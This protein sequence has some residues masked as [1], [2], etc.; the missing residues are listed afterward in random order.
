MITHSQ[1]N[2]NCCKSGCLERRGTGRVE[3]KLD[4]EIEDEVKVVLD[5]SW[6]EG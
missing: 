4:K 1:I 2:A 6:V 3:A 5:L